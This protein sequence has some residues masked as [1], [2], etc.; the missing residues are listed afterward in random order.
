MLAD[1]SIR[2]LDVYEATVIWDSQSRTIR[3]SATEV[4]PLVG[5]KLL[6]GYEVRIRMIPGGLVHID[7]VP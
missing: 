6:E 3:V 5:T 7:L 2:T 4:A 1:G